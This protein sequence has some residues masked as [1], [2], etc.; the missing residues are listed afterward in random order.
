MKV[1][2]R[3]TLEK[4]FSE[5]SRSSTRGTQAWCKACSIEHKRS[6]IKVNREKVYWNKLYT[7][8]RIR[9][10]DFEALF[11]AQNG[12]CAV[13][14]KPHV[15]HCHKTGV[16]RGLLCLRCNHLVGWLER[17]RDVLISAERYIKTHSSS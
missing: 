14:S 8:Y 6:W 15:D 3:C 13:C 4:P 16:V 5:F 1:C 11:L 10:E 12:N 2:G 17:S 9:K 7:A